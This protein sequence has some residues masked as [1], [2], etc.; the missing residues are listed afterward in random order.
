MIT[1]IVL[2]YILLCMFSAQE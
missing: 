1:D 2:R